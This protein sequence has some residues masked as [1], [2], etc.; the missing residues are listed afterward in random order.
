MVRFILA[1]LVSLGLTGF[2]AAQDS[3]IN[4]IKSSKS[5]KIGYR[6]DATPFSFVNAQKEPNG[7]TIDLCKLVVLSLEKQL[8]IQGLKIEWVPVTTQTRFDAVINGQADMECG[9]STITFTRLK[10]VDFSSIVFAETTGIVVKANAGIKS[11]ADLAGKKVAVIAG[12]TNETALNH[13]KAQGKLNVTLVSVNDRAHGVATL[14]AGAVD[15]F[16]SDKLLLV[17]TEFRDP[18]AFT[19]LPE[20]LSFEPYGIALPRGDWAF[21]PRGEYRAGACLSQRRGDGD[22]QEVV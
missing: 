17:G 15:A 12:T 11:S 10:Q 4:K 21:H 3:R 18:N 22:L 1:L 5:I 16:A 6:S 14:G 13:L 20:D 7:Y 8:G 2:A 9:S 19:L